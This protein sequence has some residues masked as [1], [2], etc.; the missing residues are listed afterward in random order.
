MSTDFWCGLR[1]VAVRNGPRITVTLDGE[2][3][4]ASAPH[5]RAT[6]LPMIRPADP[7]SEIVLDATALGFA[8]VAGIAAVVDVVTEARRCGGDAWLANPSRQ[9]TRLLKL[10]N[11]DTYVSA[12]RDAG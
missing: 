10:L 6:V 5:L 2:L 4:L 12:R 9:L 3:D 11:L 8:D 1:V 7:P